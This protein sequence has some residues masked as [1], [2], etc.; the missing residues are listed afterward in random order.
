LYTAR[1]ALAF[2]KKPWPAPPTLL[3][4]PLVAVKALLQPRRAVIPHRTLAPPRRQPRART[5]LGSMFPYRH[6]PLFIHRS[7]LFPASHNGGNT[8]THHRPLGCKAR[9]GQQR[10]EEDPPRHQDRPDQHRYRQRSQT[11]PVAASQEAL[12]PLADRLHG[13]LLSAGFLASLVSIS[14]THR[15]REAPPLLYTARPHGDPQRAQNCCPRE[16]C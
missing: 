10:A 9:Y 3:L 1:P 4:R 11:Q 8:V 5:R 16:R 12:G 7:A 2:T 13:S 6:H 14:Q 15:G